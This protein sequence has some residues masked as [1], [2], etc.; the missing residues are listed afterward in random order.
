MENR[1]EVIDTVWQGLQPMPRM[2]VNQLLATMGLS[3]N[4]YAKLPDTDAKKLFLGIVTRLDDDTLQEVVPLV[5][6]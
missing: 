6:E 5:Q 4:M 1:Q 3:K 2:K